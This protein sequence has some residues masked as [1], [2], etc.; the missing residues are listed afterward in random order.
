MTKNS[1]STSQTQVAFTWSAP[2]SNGG[3]AIIDYAVY[4]DNDNNGTYNIIGAASNVA[5]TSYTHS[6]GVSSGNTYR[7]K[8]TARNAIGSGAMSTSLAILAAEKPS[9][10]SSPTTTVSGSN[11]VTTW[12]EPATNG[13]PISAY[14]IHFKEKDNE[15]SLITSTCDGSDATIKA[16]KQCTVA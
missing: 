14:K 4:E 11:I 6:S 12:T 9:T 1:G 8:V 13:S 5:T 10:P 15:F 7:F 3:S 2:S 16:N